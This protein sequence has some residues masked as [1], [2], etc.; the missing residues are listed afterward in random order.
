[1]LCYLLQ[2]AIKVELISGSF[3][4]EKKSIPFNSKKNIYQL[5]VC[6]SG[7]SDSLRTVFLKNVSIKIYHML[8]K[9]V[10]HVYTCIRYHLKKFYRISE[11]FF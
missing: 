5:H 11:L 6:M 8:P 7:T 10:T 3:V 1:M 2:C 4:E 9:N